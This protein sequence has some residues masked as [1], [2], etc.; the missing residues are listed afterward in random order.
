[1]KVKFCDRCE[2]PIDE[3]KVFAEMNID[4]SFPDNSSGMISHDSRDADLCSE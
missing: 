2:R 3:S 4:I 1:M